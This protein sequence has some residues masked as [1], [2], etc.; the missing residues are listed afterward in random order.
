MWKDVEFFIKNCLV[1][2]RHQKTNVLEHPALALP[3]RDIN[4]RVQAD[5]VFGLPL[6]KRGN[7]G[8]ILII[9]STAKHLYIRAIKTKTAEEIGFRMF[10]YSATYGLA[11]E[12]L[13]DQGK[14]FLNKIVDALLKL[15]GTERKITSAYHPR[16]NGA[17]ERANQTIINCLRKHAENNPDDWDLWLDYIMISYN[18]RVHSSTNF[19]PYELMFGRKMNGFE[20]WENKSDEEENLSLIRRSAE[21]KKLHEIDIPN[22]IKNIEKTQETQIKSQNKGKNI[23][24]NSLEPNSKV[25]IK[26]SMLQGK[27]DAKYRGPYTVVRRTD[28]GNYILKNNNGIEL[29]SSYPLNKLK[30]VCDTVE[31]KDE[32]YDIE[33]VIKERTRN[34]K[35]E[36]YVKWKN[37]S[38]EHN[39]WVKESDFVSMEWLDE[40]HR[41]KNSTNLVDINQNEI[42]HST[43]KFSVNSQVI[44]SIILI[45]LLFPLTYGQIIKDKFKFCTFNGNNQVLVSSNCNENKVNSFFNSGTYYLLEKTPYHINGH[46]YL[47]N[48]DIIKVVTYVTF[49]GSKTTNREVIHEIL[50]R[51]DCLSMVIS[52]KCYS[53]EMTCNNNN[54]KSE[55]IPKINF[56]WLSELTFTSFYCNTYKI[57]IKGHSLISPLFAEAKTSCLPSDLFCRVDFLTYIWEK[58]II[59]NCPFNLI[60]EKTIN[61]TDGI[62]VTKNQLFQLNSIINEC[63]MNMY[64]TSEGIYLTDDAKAK[65]LPKTINDINVE[66]HL[67]LSD[68]DFRTF[69]LFNIMIK[70]SN[71]ISREIC[72]TNENI[73]ENNLDKY[74]EFF[75]INGLGKNEIIYNNYGELIVTTCISIDEIEIIDSEILY[76]E[77]K[78]KFTYQNKSLI[79]FLTKNGIIRSSSIQVDIEKLDVFRLPSNA[80]ILRKGKNIKLKNSSRHK[81]MLNTIYFN[82]KINYNH[83]SE[84][85]NN[86]DILKEIEVFTLNRNNDFVIKDFLN[87][88]NIDLVEK[89]N[90]KEFGN[91][92]KFFKSTKFLIIIIILLLFCSLAIILVIIFRNKLKSCFRKDKIEKTN[93][94]EVYELISL[95]EK[96]QEEKNDNLKEI[97]V[98]KTSTTNL[99]SIWKLN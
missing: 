71:K 96:I 86:Y 53:Q 90:L 70:F 66:N 83:A 14:E 93:S 47:C 33:K 74:D 79:G 1:C 11:K 75:V 5:L 80:L 62:A 67:I 21:I 20:K 37:Y 61:I 22:A 77:L 30:P 36:Y 73:V 35:K 48:R 26:V 65:L 85:L 39:S 57:P 51:D 23:I 13:S 60:S 6:T 32:T 54:C 76:K 2:I 46:G 94:N 7:K 25:F 17:S 81:L 89:K 3:I 82:D 8:I 78:V 50:S 69:K 9:E 63:D 95:K 42:H 92:A 43:V 55:K 52:K 41:E 18:S 16:T 68:I 29:K 40:Y 15:C 99:N 88:N 49:F 12:W 45:L 87:T 91:I 44:F 10:R 31:D 34:G 28:K 98:S 97:Q 19:T 4:D 59:F 72:L 84:L 64:T 24:N 56:A 58:D 27:L 38:D